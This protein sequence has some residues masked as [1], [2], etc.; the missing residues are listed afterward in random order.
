MVLA[1]AGP[2]AI[3]YEHASGQGD[4]L[5][6]NGECNG[7]GI[8]FPVGD[9]WNEVISSTRHQWCGTVKH[10]SGPGATGDVQITN[11]GFGVLNNVNGQLNDRVSSTYY[12]A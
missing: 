10:F 9:P 1:A 4:S 8:T 3:H 6:I 11:G 5:L 7:S 12:F 2:L